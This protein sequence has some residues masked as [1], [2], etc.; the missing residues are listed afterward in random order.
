M[1]G[2][3]QQLR[4]LCVLAV[5]SSCSGPPEDERVGFLTPP[6]DS[7]APPSE[8]LGAHCGSLDCHGQTGR[9]LRL[10][11]V[12]GL[13]LPANVSGSGVTTPEEHDA[14][15][16]SVVLLEPER[17]TLFLQ[18]GARELD[19]LTIVRKA[20]GSEEHKGGAPWAPGSDADRCL[21]SWLRGNVDVEA[22]ARSAE[23]Q[24]PEFP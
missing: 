1:T 10:Y 23:I 14:N 24:R 4:V 6:R 3:W 11:H 12:N 18:Q 9:S 15:F 13:R 7:F 22:C 16:Q 19:A 21:T 8:T 2:R 20:R 5:L 17:L